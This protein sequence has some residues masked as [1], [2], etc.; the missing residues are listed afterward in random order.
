M[1]IVSLLPVGHRDRVRL[2]LG[3]DLMG[4][5]D[6]CDFPADAV[7]K[8]VVSRSALPQGRPLSSREIDAAVRERMDAK[9]PLYVLDT[10]LLRREQPDVILTQDLCRVCAV[11]A[12]HVEEALAAARRRRR[13]QGRLAGSAHARGRDRP[14]RGRG[15]APRR[16]GARR[17]ARRRPPRSRVAAVKQKAARLPSV[18]VL[19]HG[20]GGNRRS[21]PA[22][23][24]PRWSRPWGHQPAQRRRASHRATRHPPGDPRREARGA[25]LHAVRLLPG[26]GR[27]GGRDGSS[28]TPRSPTRPPRA[29]ATCSRSTP[30]RS[31]RGP[32]PGSST[33]SRSSRGRPTPRPTPSR[34]PARSSGCG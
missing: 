3:D 15:H 25:G 21:S 27:G 22:I 8:P 12:G 34:P 6:E 17:G 28:R 1:K 2:G 24:S 18:G 11:P 13:H 19:L 7:T 16:R 26:G 9:Q 32:G 14:A 33:A 10:D 29:T 31:S 4:V 23:G 20:L 30:R 5:T